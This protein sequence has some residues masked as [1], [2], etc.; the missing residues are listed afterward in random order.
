MSLDQFVGTWV[1][2]KKEGF[3]GLAAALGL[4]DE[5]RTFFENSQSQL[6]YERDGDTWTIHVGIVGIPQT[7]T[8]TFKMG[9]L[10]DSTNIDG[11]PLKSVIRQDGSRLVE[12]HESNGQRTFVMD[13][14]RDVSGD[15]MNATTSIGGMAMQTIYKRV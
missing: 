8:F 10:Y 1:E 13:I 11:S 5:Q 3:H 2:A 12:R 4:S 9:Q 7:T 6:T 14:V 15:T